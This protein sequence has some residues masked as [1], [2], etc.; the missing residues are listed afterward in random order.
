MK[1]RTLIYTVIVVALFEKVIFWLGVFTAQN[2]TEQLGGIWK[3]TFIFTLAAGLMAY[4]VFSH[5][6]APV[7]AQGLQGNRP[8]WGQED[9]QVGAAMH[10]SGPAQ[11]QPRPMPRPGLTPA[12]IHPM[13]RSSGH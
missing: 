13:Q 6:E 12:I 10:Q 11:A 9:R 8:A 4:W 1:K 2:P 5:R 3:I 7:E